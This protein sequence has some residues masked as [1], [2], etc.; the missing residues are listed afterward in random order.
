MTQQQVVLITGVSSGFGR[1]M[2][3][4]FARAGD[5]VFAGLRDGTGRNAKA[6]GELEALGVEVLE[7]DVTSD[8]QVEAAVARVIERR[9]QID[10]LINNAGIGLAAISECSSLEQARRVFET[11]Y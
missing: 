8:A 4:T 3:E 9:G 1:L 10:V 6:R 7:L 11:N 2:A 5:A